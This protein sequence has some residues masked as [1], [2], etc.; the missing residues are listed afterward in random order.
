MKEIGIVKNVYW[1]NEYFGG[2]QM[3][4]LYIKVEPIRGN[5]FNFGDI[6][7]LCPQF[8]NDLSIIDFII[9]EIEWEND[10][11]EI[12]KLLLI[13]K[14]AAPI[15]IKSFDCADALAKVLISLKVYGG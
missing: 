14:S 7:R 4:N 2:S 8:S 3:H 5:T 1:R 10:F 9:K 13:A 11:N 12:G 6:L 15:E